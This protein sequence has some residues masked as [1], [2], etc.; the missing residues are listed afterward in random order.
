MKETRISKNLSIR[1]VPTSNGFY[2]GYI[3]KD[4]LLVKDD[5]NTMLLNAEL[6]DGWN[7]ITETCFTRN[8]CKRAAKSWVKQHI[9]DELDIRLEKR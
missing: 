5:K 9:I 4:P 6:E 3:Y 7:Q 1:V 8:G 2:I